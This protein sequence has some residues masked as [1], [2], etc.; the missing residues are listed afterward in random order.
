MVVTEAR[1][2][3]EPILPQPLPC[4]KTA[5]SLHCREGWIQKQA[6]V[7]I[8][9]SRQ[10]AKLISRADEILEELW[11]AGLKAQPLLPLGQ[12]QK[13][14]QRKV[15]SDLEQKCYSKLKMGRRNLMIYMLIPEYPQNQL[16]GVILELELKGSFNRIIPALT[17][18]KRNRI[19]IRLNIVSI[20]IIY[21]ETG[22]HH[23]HCRPKR[24]WEFQ[25][26]HVKGFF[27]S[28]CCYTGL[29]ER[30]VIRNMITS[31]H[32]KKLMKN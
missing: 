26:R 32:L 24:S 10:H 21:E 19:T 8:G 15:F 6:Q 16:L 3:A 25:A 11:F 31:R 18:S 12:A 17:Q 5:K 28:F 4:S 29:E 22:N 23:L 2:K 14:I 20:K 1:L 7:P 27:S 9:L 13:V 30:L